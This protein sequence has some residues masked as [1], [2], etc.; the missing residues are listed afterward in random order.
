MK[1]LKV[2][3][4]FLLILLLTIVTQVGGLI[5]I[6]TLLLCKYKNWKKRYTYLILYLVCKSSRSTFGKTFW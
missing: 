6:V 3:F 4:H 1:I 2:I 5:W